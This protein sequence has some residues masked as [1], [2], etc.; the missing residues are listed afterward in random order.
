MAM[1]LFAVT[2]IYFRQP[3]K[4]NFNRIP[5]SSSK[6]TYCSLICRRFSAQPSAS[7]SKLLRTSHPVYN[8]AKNSESLPTQTASRC[9]KPHPQLQKKS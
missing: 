1:L 9:S 4:I 5:S 8:F 2:R 7:D 6:L 3:E